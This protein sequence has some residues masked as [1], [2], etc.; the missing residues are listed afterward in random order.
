MLL[1]LTKDNAP[2]E[3]PWRP[4]DLPDRFERDKPAL[5]T[6]EMLYFGFFVAFVVAE[7]F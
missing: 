3:T 5:N 4:A 7:I 2:P 6:D 1:V